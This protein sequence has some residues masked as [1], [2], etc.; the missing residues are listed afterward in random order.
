M[1][2]G[3]AV[4]WVFYFYEYVHMVLATYASLPVATLLFTVAITSRTVRL[5]EL[6]F[7]FRRT[8]S[9]SN[10]KETAH[11][12]FPKTFSKTVKENDT[13]VSRSD[14]LQNPAIYFFFR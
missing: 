11:K 14:A 3:R 7:W 8:P 9:S 6:F 13:Q 1:S 12:T 4:R 5:L 2:A 10:H